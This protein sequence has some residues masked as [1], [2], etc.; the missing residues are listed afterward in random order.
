MHRQVRT[1][2]EHFPTEVHI[3]REEIKKNDKTYKQKR[4]RYHDKHHRVRIHTIKCGDAVLIKR[5]KRKKY[6]P[7]ELYVYIVTSS[8][9]SAIRGRS[10]KDGKVK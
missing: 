10:V 7:Y 3:T 4:K 5:E 1:R 8:K 2:L 6:T 9:R